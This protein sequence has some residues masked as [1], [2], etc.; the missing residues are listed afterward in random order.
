M[1]F[2]LSLYHQAL[3][4]SSGQ[5]S[6]RKISRSLEAVIFGLSPIALRFYRL[7]G[8]CAAEMPD[9]IQNDT[10]IMASNLKAPRFHVFLWWDVSVRLTNRGPEIYFSINPPILNCNNKLLLLSFNNRSHRYLIPVDIF[11][12]LITPPDTSKNIISF[13]EIRYSI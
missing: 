4:S 8:S 10:I 7:I 13:G 2:S 3:Y 11:L 1:M 12:V 5:T 6:Y 9:K